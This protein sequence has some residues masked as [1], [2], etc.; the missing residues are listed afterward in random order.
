MRT[1]LLVSTRILQLFCRMVMKLSSVKTV[2][3]A[4]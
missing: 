1:L 4:R 2:K 3:S